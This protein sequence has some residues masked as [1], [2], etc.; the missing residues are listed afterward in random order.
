MQIITNEHQKEL[1]SHGSYAFPVY[2][3]EEVLCNYERGSFM[4][5]WHPEIELTFITDGEIMY[6]VNNQTYHLQ[7]GD[8][9][10]CNANALHTGHMVN[11]SD[12]N[13]VSITFHPRMVYGYDGSSIHQNYVKPVINSHAFGSFCFKNGVNWQKNILDKMHDI[14]SYFFKK[15][16]LYEFK[17]QQ[18]LTDIWLIIYENYIAKENVDLV[19]SSSSRDIDRLRKILSYLDENYTEKITLEDIADS[20]GLCKAECCRFFKRIMNQSL[21]DYIPLYRIEKSL[22]LLAQKDLSVTE[23][24]EQTGFTSSSYYARVFKEHFNCSPSEYRKR[25]I[26]SKN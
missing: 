11:S 7:K 2:V 25:M 15:E 8:G 17:I 20:V 9:L 10:F 4:W 12:C 26:L 14:Y 22:P 1:K 3:S 16:A 5:H 13:Y 23:I 18:C 24:A 21:F 6:Q 19:D